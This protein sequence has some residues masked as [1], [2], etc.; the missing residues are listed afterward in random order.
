[1]N[2][3]NNAVDGLRNLRFLGNFDLR[4]SVGLDRLEEL[5][6]LVA[7]LL[8]LLAI[9]PVL[10]A[11]EPISFFFSS[12]L[13]ISSIG[14]IFLFLFLSLVFALLIKLFSIR[15]LFRVF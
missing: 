8:L 4:V 1:M 5:L 6:K 2:E 14:G 9:K 15:A 10:E 7:T 11:L 3:R 13:G 12:V